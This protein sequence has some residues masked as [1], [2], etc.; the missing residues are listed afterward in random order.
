M[1]SSWMGDRYTLHTFGWRGIQVWTNEGPH[2]FPRGDNYQIVIIH[3]QNLKIFISRT[4]WP[5]QPNLAQS[6]FG[7]RGF[8]FVQ[9]IDHI[10][11]REKIPGNIEIAKYILTRFRSLFLQNQR[12]NFNKTVHK[13]SL[14]KG[15]SILLKW[16]ATLLSK[17][18]MIRTLNQL[19]FIIM[20]LFRLIYC[21]ELFPT[22][23]F[24]H[25]PDKQIQ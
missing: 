20:A 21:L 5:F 16:K 22:M 1:I 6:I 10:F 13:A 9:M 8:K 14:V 7:W 2:P 25:I 12:D 17:K 24:C 11:F 4:T 19:A 18:K 23:S 15:N 3:W